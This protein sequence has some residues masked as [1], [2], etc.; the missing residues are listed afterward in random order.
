MPD[1]KVAQSSETRCMSF[2]SLSSRY[3]QAEQYQSSIH[4]S[5]L[6]I[7]AV[8]AAAAEVEA[9]SRPRLVAEGST[10]DEHGPGG[11]P[12]FAVE[13]VEEVA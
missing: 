3:R 8:L 7:L 13:E 11:Y 12:A 10:D 6:E 4:P 5:R 9:N 1:D 2:R